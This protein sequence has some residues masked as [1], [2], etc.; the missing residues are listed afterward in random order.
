MDDIKEPRTSNPLSRRQFL[1]A[2]TTVTAG[3]ALAGCAPSQAS[4]SQPSSAPAPAT[5]AA[6]AAAPTGASAPATIKGTMK[7]GHPTNLSGSMALY[8]LDAVTAADLA[9]EQRNQKGGVLGKWV[10]IVREDLVNPGITVQKVTKLLE[11]DKVECLV[12]GLSS[13]DAAAIAQMAEQHKKLY[14]GTGMNADAL[15]LADCRRYT[16]YIE[17]ANLM[18]VKAIGSYLV[19]DAGKGS[20]WYFITNDYAYGQSLYQDMSEVVKGTG[21]TEIANDLVPMGTSDFTSYILKMKDAK[22]DVVGVSLSGTDL[23]AFGKQ[24]KSFG[25]PYPILWPDGDTNGIWSVGYKNLPANA[26]WPAH[27]YF[28]LPGEWNE[29]FVNRFRNKIGRPPASQGYQETIGFNIVFEAMEKAGST[30]SNTL[31]QFLESGYKFDIGKDRKVYFNTPYDHQLMTPLYILKLKPE[32][33]VKDEWDI[34]D[35]VQEIPGPN[36]PLE[37]LWVPPGQNTCKLPSL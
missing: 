2:I 26:A 17:T 28:R 22:P 20:R 12:G 33:K 21:A 36:D 15:R 25:L 27:W 16:F 32:D 6:P 35:I 13:A 9:V 30:D 4:P 7:I 18:L 31:V 34:L 1:K 14:V 11:K 37:S 29:D 23:A 3:A 8:T 5:G 24:Y 19:K 10:E